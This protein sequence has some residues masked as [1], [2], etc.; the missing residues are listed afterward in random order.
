MTIHD[1]RNNCV[2]IALAYASGLPETYVMRVCLA[3]G[4]KRGMRVAQWLNAARALGLHLTKVKLPRPDYSGTYVKRTTLHQFQNFMAQQGV[5]YLVRTRS[6]LL[7][8]DDGLVYDPNC[9]W[10]TGKRR[11]WGVYQ[12]TKE[13]PMNWHTTLRIPMAW[14]HGDVETVLELGDDGMLRFTAPWLSAPVLGELVVVHDDTAPG[15][16][17]LPE[18]RERLDLITAQ[19]VGVEDILESY[20]TAHLRGQTS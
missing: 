1:Y 14:G 18:W 20:L 13:A 5:L 9:R 3:H 10:G 19:A 7:V 16:R 15:P 11:I 8:V 2:P 17:A 12:V 6:H 4:F